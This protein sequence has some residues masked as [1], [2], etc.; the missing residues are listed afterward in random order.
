MENKMRD[1]KIRNNANVGNEEKRYYGF[2]YALVAVIVLLLAFGL[3]MLY[4][5][6]Y[7][8][9]QTKYGND[10][11]FLRKQLIFAV[12]G[13]WLMLLVSNVKYTVYK[14]Y[15]KHIFVGAIILMLLVQTPL[16]VE[17]GGSAR[18]L[19]LFG[20]QFQPSELMK[21]A[22]IIHLPAVLLRYKSDQLKKEALYV[23]LM[24]IIG[25]VIAVYV[26]TD[27]LSTAIIVGGI[28]VAVTLVLC[29]EFNKIIQI[30]LAVMV[31]GIVFIKL[32]SE[33][34][35]ENLHGFRWKRILVW[36]DVE[37]YASGGGYQ[38]LQALYAIGAGGIFGKGLGNGTQKLSSIP[39]VQNDMIFA[40]ICEELGIFGMCILLMLFGYMLFRLHIIAKNAPTMYSS[41]VVHGIWAHIAI[42]VILNIAVVTAILPNTGVTLPFISYGGTALMIT[43]GELGLALGISR[44]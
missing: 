34:I 26:L 9:G 36:I 20:I 13:F 19:N 40:A 29:K 8:I 41:L 27:N 21:V 30:F 7:H 42:Q 38:V 22:I 4:S 23:P 32:F 24:Y 5:I 6:S 2:D 35:I 25:S 12:G 1:R 43:L 44:L 37:A 33:S 31:S 17:A 39:E 16:G 10:M 28:G 3:V 11:F 15:S 14:K 18:W